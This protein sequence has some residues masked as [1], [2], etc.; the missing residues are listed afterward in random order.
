MISRLQLSAVL[1]VLTS[2]GLLVF[3]QMAS[4]Y[5]DGALYRK[6]FESRYHQLYGFLEST[7]V[8][9]YTNSSGQSYGHILQ[10]I[11]KPTSRGSNRIGKKFSLNRAVRSATLSFDV[12]LHSQFEFVNGGKMH[13]LSGGTSTTGCKPIDENGF[14]VRMMWRA[15]GVPVLYIYHQDRQN[16]CGD[17]FYS[18]SDFKFERGKWYRIEIFVRLNTG[19]GTSDGR[20][21]LY[22]NGKHRIDV[23]N[24][25]LRGNNHTKIDTFLF[26]TFYGGSS[27]W[28]SPSETTYAYF[29]NFTVYPGRRVGGREATNCEIFKKGIYNASQRA[30]C[31]NSCGSC[32]GAGCGR[33]SGGANQCCTSK[34]TS[35]G[36]WCISDGQLAPCAYYDG[37][38]PS[39]DPD[40]DP[41]PEP[42]CPYF[43][44]R[45][46]TWVMCP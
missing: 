15:K 1:A 10:A 38:P 34:V 30:C 43:D 18:A 39:D 16:D 22:I 14:S 2:F 17:N 27:T 32:G 24:L 46:G 3:S 45:R 36:E 5:T 42:D 23:Q 7:R 19:K 21:S 33:L 41:V 28:W 37:S 44:E 20:A 12:K 9:K 4:A 13:G 40:P 35:S 26:S 29:D 11:Y 31:S 6:N 8:K 25:N